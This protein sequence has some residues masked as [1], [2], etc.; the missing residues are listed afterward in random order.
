MN[1]NNM[2]MLRKGMPPGRSLFRQSLAAAFGDLTNPSGNVE[3][4]GN[5]YAH[6]TPFLSWRTCLEGRLDDEMDCQDT[7]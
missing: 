3:F 1:S 5:L 2:P 6:T 7:T 4:Q